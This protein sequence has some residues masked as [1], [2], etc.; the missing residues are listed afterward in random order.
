MGNYFEGGI[1]LTNGCI[2]Y[3]F[4]FNKTLYGGINGYT[5]VTAQYIPTRRQPFTCTHF[6][7]PCFPQPAFCHLRYKSGRV[8]GILF[9]IRIERMVEMC[10]G[11]GSEQEESANE[12]ESY[13]LPT[14]AQKITC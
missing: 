11:A 14:I 2:K 5:T 4:Y 10:I 3:C 13:L 12:E 9:H 1:Y 8:P 7:Y 6:T